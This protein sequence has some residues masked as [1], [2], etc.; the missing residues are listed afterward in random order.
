MVS[1]SREKKKRKYVRSNVHSFCHFIENLTGLTDGESLP[2][3]LC[4]VFACEPKL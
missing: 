2:F 4:G 1:K 3:F